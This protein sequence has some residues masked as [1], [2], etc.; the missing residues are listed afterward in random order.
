MTKLILRLTSAS[1]IAFLFVCISGCRTQTLL[2]IADRTHQPAHVTDTLKIDE[3][4]ITI[5]PG[6]WQNAM[7]SADENPDPDPKVYLHLN[8]VELNGVNIHGQFRL[9]SLV[10]NTDSEHKTWII[11]K[12]P[13]STSGPTWEAVTINTGLHLGQQ[14]TVEVFG[15]DITRQTKIMFRLKLPYMQI[16]Y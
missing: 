12:N 6:F 11:K 13:Y 7:P 10:K 4:A 16:A 1:L 2:P 8:L 5:Y 15:T 3:Y 14:N 9:D